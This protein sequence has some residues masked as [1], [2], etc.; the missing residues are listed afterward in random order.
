MTNIDDVK[1]FWDRNPCNAH[2]SS[3]SVGTKTYFEDIEKRRYFVHPHVREFAGFSRWDKSDVLEVGFGIGI[4]AINFARHGA[5]Y[6]GVELSSESLKIA[7][8]NFDLFNL[9][10]TLIEGNAEFL[11]E[12]FPENSFDMVYSCGVL[13]H[14]PNPA[15]AI[16]QIRSVLRPNGELRLMLYAKNSW[17]SIMISAG[18]DQ[19]EAA[20][21]CP[22]AQQYTRD[23]A[24]TL[25]DG[26]QIVSMEQR[27]IFPYDV[28]E[29]RNHN[30][31]KVP[32]FEAMPQKMFEALERNLG[33]HLL[34]VAKP[35]NAV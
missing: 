8:K 6:T 35:L 18:L 16:E 28:K 22:L 21:G 31:V 9:P 30:Y 33:W 5:N 15:K 17:K 23:E 1:E 20:S 27:H 34:I 11:T 29:Y 32:W 2:H 13:H 14:T 25:L 3:A 24:I 10:R 7:Q 26:F 12:Y 19:P 4:D